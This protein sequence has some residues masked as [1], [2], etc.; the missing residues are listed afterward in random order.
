MQRVFMMLHR[1]TWGTS[2][3]PTKRSASFGD[4][5]SLRK[6]GRGMCFFCVHSLMY[7]SISRVFPF[8][9]SPDARKNGSKDGNVAKCVCDLQSEESPRSSHNPPSTQPLY[10]RPSSYLICSNA[11][12]EEISL[13]SCVIPPECNLIRICINECCSYNRCRRICESR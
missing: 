9:R 2:Y 3:F 4:D 7:Q 5:A 1:S 11:F 6:S 10:F 12:L 8:T 13:I